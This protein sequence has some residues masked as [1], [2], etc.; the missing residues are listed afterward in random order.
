MKLQASSGPG[1]AQMMH[2][3]TW[4][5]H[6]ERSIRP[7]TAGSIFWRR[8]SPPF[9]LHILE[10][11]AQSKDL[12]YAQTHEIPRQSGMGG[13]LSRS[14]SRSS[15]D[16]IVVT[17]LVPI[18]FDKDRDEDR[19]NDGETTTIATTIRKTMNCAIFTL[20]SPTVRDVSR[21]EVTG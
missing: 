13:S 14:L 19:D 1:G 18:V 3:E 8:R 17:I 11:A 4:A 15:S 6:P 9:C 5:C 10:S 16:F 21:H 2:V 7:R 20:R 12:A